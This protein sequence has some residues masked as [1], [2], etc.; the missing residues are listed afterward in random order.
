MHTAPA[1][2][3][4]SVDFFISQS[5]YIV[6]HLPEEAYCGSEMPRKSDSQCA[7]KDRYSVDTCSMCKRLPR[8]PLESESGYSDPQDILTH[9][10][11]Y[12][13]LMSIVG[14]TFNIA[15]VNTQLFLST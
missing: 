14:Y 2:K 7:V 4:V 5:L 12:S 10:P 13:L 6:M 11:R 8:H 1:A 15:D 9:F 3:S